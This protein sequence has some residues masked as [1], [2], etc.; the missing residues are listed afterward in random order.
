MQIK[1]LYPILLL[2]LLFSHCIQPYEPDTYSYEN[3]LVIDGKI[4][5]DPGP[6]QIRLSYTSEIK[7]PVY[8]PVSNAIVEVRNTSGNTYRFENLGEGLFISNAFRGKPGEGYQ[9]K[10]S[11]PGGKE[12]ESNIQYIRS[13]PDIDS[14][15]YSIEEVPT[16]NEHY[17]LEGLQFYVTTHDPENDC[18]FFL[19]LLDET[20]L[21]H[22][23]FP[24]EYFVYRY[25]WIVPKDRKMYY[26]CYRSN[27][28]ARYFTY[29]ASNLEKVKL[30]EMPLHFVSTET[31]QLTERYSLLVNQYSVNEE[32]YFYYN[33][34]NNQQTEG[35]DLY[36]KQPFQIPGNVECI[37]H[38]EE[39]TLG[40]FLVAG[41][42]KKRIFVNNPGLVLRHA[43][44][45]LQTEG[46][47]YA[48]R[49]SMQDTIYLGTNID[50]EI[51][52]APEACFDCRM[53]G[54]TLE[55][56]DFWEDY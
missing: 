6:Y 3:Q 8:R 15:S 14:I 1:P 11:L 43:T 52:V 56:P 28:I 4:T 50:G 40:Y 45:N 48:L 41:V 33:S 44:C 39:K 34:L 9:L 38:P 23:D 53:R 13:V 21:Y 17:Y 36:S 27:Q 19:W 10:I 35:D 25:N 30:T 18:Q 22:A 47:G 55:K 32:A 54:G 29:N 5:D 20:Y 7:N 49:G 2:I 26:T 42:S 24:I 16:S 46:Y 31:R 51:G 12:Y 37:S